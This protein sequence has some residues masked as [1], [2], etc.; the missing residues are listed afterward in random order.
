MEPLFNTSTTTLGE[1]YTLFPIKETEQDLYKLY[2]G[3]NILNMFRQDNGYK[4]KQYIKTWD[5]DKQDND[6]MMEFLKDLTVEEVEEK[7]Y[8]MMRNFY[9]SRVI[10]KEN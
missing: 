4:I 9:L 10:N 2:M 6:F 8:S 7:L 5:I 1:R 3:K